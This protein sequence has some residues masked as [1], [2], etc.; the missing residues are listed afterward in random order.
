MSLFTK[1]LSSS[2]TTHQNK[3]PRPHNSTWSSRTN[4]QLLNKHKYSHWHQWNMHTHTHTHVCLMR[5]THQR[6]ATVSLC[7]LNV[8]TNL[9]WAPTHTH[10]HTHTHVC[11]CVFL[12]PCSSA[13]NTTESYQHE[14]AT[15]SASD[16]FMIF[17]YLYVCVCVCRY[18]AQRRCLAGFH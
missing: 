9:A 11:V 6:E 13:L 2:K 14:S 16:C 3:S 15:M 1:R 10:T 18:L 5:C 8:C 7:L 17:T 12:Q 4:A